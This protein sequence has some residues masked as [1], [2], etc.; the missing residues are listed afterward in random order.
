MVVALTAGWST[1][2]AALPLLPPPPITLPTLTLPTTSPRDRPPGDNAGRDDACGNDA[3]AAGSTA[4][5]AGPAGPARD[6]AGLAASSIRPQATPDL[7]GSAG[8]PTRPI[9][10]GGQTSREQ[11]SR[12]RLARDWIAHRGADGKRRTT[13][14]FI[15]RRPALIEFVVLQ[16]APDCRRIGR[17]RV[18]GHRGVNRV[19]VPTGSVANRWRPGRTGSWRER[20]RPAERS[21]ARGSSSSIARAGRDP[22]G[23]ESGLLRAELEC[24]ERQTPLD[25]RPE[26]SAS[27]PGRR[28]H[29]TLYATTE[30]SERGSPR[31]PS[32]PPKTFRSGSTSWLASRSRCSERRRLYPK[33]ENVGLSASLLLGLVGATILLGLTI[34]YAFG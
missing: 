15:L 9:R 33:T 30:C 11:A 21:G 19:Q 27:R 25:H 4:G 20:F 26:L 18:R 6:A 7:R 24:R 2:A 13:L 29:G 28:A 23:P 16:V 10:E 14:V 22:S 3:D 32:S 1:S 31:A 8:A 5:S 17:F 12:L 34:T